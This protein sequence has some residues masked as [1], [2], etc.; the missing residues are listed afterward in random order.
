MLM[1]PVRY[2]TLKSIKLRKRS[3]LLSVNYNK[4]YISVKDPDGKI[5]QLDTNITYNDR[6]KKVNDLIEKYSFRMKDPKSWDTI[7]TR[8][9][10]E[11]LSN[12][13]LFDKTKVIEEHNKEIK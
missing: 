3:W 6:L 4:D 10:I 1:F 7:P 12:Y 11:S 9:F 8:Y 5:I 13:L 2:D